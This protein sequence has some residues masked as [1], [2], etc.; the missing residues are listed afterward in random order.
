MRR[1]ARVGGSAVCLGIAVPCARRKPFCRSVNKEEHEAAWLV[2]ARAR[3][4][5]GGTC[6][7]LRT[8]RMVSTAKCEAV[9]STSIFPADECRAL[10]KCGVN[11]QE[12]G[13]FRGLVWCRFPHC[14]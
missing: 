12:T 4:P 6:V 13:L 2:Q 3:A 5:F 10:I 14:L 7:Q 11:E 8:N 1:G 9:R